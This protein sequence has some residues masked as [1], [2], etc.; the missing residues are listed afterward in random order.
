M[1]MKVHFI[2]LGN[3]KSFFEEKSHDIR[4]HKYM[5]KTYCRNYR[6]Q[7]EC[8]LQIRWSHC[9]YVFPCFFHLHPQWCLH[10]TEAGKSIKN[11]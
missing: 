7:W 9:A 4:M 5:F 11:V 1:K 10:P 2:I 8:S 3:V 6:K